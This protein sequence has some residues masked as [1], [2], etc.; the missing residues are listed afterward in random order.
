MSA[1]V[2]AISQGVFIHNVFDAVE[3]ALAAACDRSDIAGFLCNTHDG[4]TMEVEIHGRDCEDKGLIHFTGEA[5][6]HGYGLQA[7][8]LVQGVLGTTAVCGHVQ[9]LTE[10]AEVNDEEVTRTVQSPLT[11][12]PYHRAR[13]W[14]RK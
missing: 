5:T 2:H 11:P 12:C 14:A 10:E 13:L 6:V 3:D 4:F 8:R 7:K 9:L 1:R